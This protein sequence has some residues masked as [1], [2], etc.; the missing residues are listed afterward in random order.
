LVTEDF[1]IYTEC[2]GGHYSVRLYWKS[3]NI[4]FISCE[5]FDDNSKS[6]WIHVYDYFGGHNLNFYNLNLQELINEIKKLYEEGKS[7]KDVDFLGNK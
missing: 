2:I 6:G 5:R 4:A 7:L 3:D 1:D